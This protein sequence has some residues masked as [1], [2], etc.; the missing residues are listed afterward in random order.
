MSK[1]LEHCQK[2]ADEVAVIM[3]NNVNSVIER[4]GKLNDL[5]VRSEKLLDMSANF[6]KTA[7]K[8]ERKT[9]WKTTKCK[10]I[11]GVVVVVIFILLIVV[12]VLIVHFS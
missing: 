5:E 6:V 2:E 3:L 7:V 10:I 1:K 4:D 9:R 11:A 12:V 8:V